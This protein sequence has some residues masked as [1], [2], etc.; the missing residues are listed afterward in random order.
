MAR[1]SDAVGATYGKGVETVT[2]GVRRRS[3]RGVGISRSGWTECIADILD[4]IIVEQE[5]A[6]EIFSRDSVVVDGV[7]LL[8]R[9]KVVAGVV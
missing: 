6:V 4:A 3:S 2:D 1:A 9:R 8:I 7:K 5:V